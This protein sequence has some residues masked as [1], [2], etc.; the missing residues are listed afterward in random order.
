[1]KRLLLLGEENFLLSFLLLSLHFPAELGEGGK[2]SKQYGV[3]VQSTRC[4]SGKTGALFHVHHGV[5]ELSWSQAMSTPGLP[6]L[7]PSPG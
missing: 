6:G 2:G 5:N 7:E 3:V 1:M 4:E